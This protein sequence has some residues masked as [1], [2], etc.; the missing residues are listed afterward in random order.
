MVYDRDRWFNVISAAK[1]QIVLKA[2]RRRRRKNYLLNLIFYNTNLPYN[3]VN[4][5]K[6]GVE[7]IVDL[8]YF[9]KNLF[10]CIKICFIYVKLYSLK[11]LIAYCKHP[12]AVS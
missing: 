9:R 12:K 6:K 8:Y 2:S 4:K 10:S 11:N 7:M 3:F 5:S 1:I